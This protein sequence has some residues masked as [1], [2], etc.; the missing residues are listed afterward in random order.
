MRENQFQKWLKNNYF[1]NWQFYCSYY[2]A[3][4]SNFWEDC[5][6]YLSG[7][8]QITCEKPTRLKISSPNQ[9]ASEWLF[10]FESW[11]WIEQQGCVFILLKSAFQSPCHDLWLTG[12]SQRHSMKWPLKFLF[13]LFKAFCSFWYVSIELFYY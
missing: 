4:H 7:Y 12:A 9:S 2:A 10:D 3:V 13:Y 5:S 6:N 1:T 11:S 8:G